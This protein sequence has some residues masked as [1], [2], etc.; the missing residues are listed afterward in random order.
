MAMGFT[1]EAIKEEL[2]EGEPEHYEIWPEHKDAYLVFVAVY[3]Q[4]RYP[5][6]GGKPIGLEYTAL[7]CEIEIMFPEKQREIWQQ[8]KHIERGALSAWH[9]QSE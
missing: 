6:L 7:R 8:V 1:D 5:P 9:N 2:E 4:W 3:H